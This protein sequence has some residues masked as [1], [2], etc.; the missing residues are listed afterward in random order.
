MAYRLAFALALILMP[1]TAAAQLSAVGV[2]VALSHHQYVDVPS[3]C[4]PPLACATFGEGRWRLQVDYLRSYREAAVH[5]NYPIDDVDGWRASVQRADR[6]IE[7]QHHAS[8]LV[9]WRVLEDPRHSLGIL[10]G[11]AYVH[12]KQA[13][14]R[15]SEG[16]VVQI[17]TPGLCVLRDGFDIPTLPWCL[18]P[19]AQRA[20]PRARGQ[21]E[22]RLR[23]RSLWRPESF[24]VI[25]GDTFQHR[26]GETGWHAFWYQRANPGSSAQRSEVNAHF[27]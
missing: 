27:D 26:K 21:A 11:G 19:W 13:D 8:V 18:D 20:V 16:P 14:C 7:S 23:H 22:C 2:G 1:T 25:D 12:A 9:S 3:L 17:P 5:G 10:F 6:D 24:A 15:A 4:C